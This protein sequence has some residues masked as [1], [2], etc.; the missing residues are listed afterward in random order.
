M[1]C[2]IHGFWEFRTPDGSW[3]AFKKINE[4]QTYDWFG[5]IANVRA[6]TRG[7]KT[8]GRGIPDDCSSAWRQ[9]TGA[10]GR[11]LF[12]HTWLTPHEVRLANAELLKLHKEY[13]EEYFKACDES[14]EETSAARDGLTTKDPENYYEPVPD[15]ATIVENLIIHGPGNYPD[16]MTWCGTLSENLK[17]DNID[18]NIRMVVAF[19][20]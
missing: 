3:I 16:T 1:G 6:V 19:D 10:W 14:G 12:G 4:G 7:S 11:G 17:T 13:D 2:D 8:A 15:G 20:N 5:I 18:E 9:Y